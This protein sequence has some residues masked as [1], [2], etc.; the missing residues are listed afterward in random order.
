MKLSGWIFC[1]EKD[2][3]SKWMSKKEMVSSTSDRMQSYWSLSWST[4]REDTSLR[5]LQEEGAKS[6]KA[7]NFC[8]DQNQQ[9]QWN[10]IAMFMWPV[11]LVWENFR[12]INWR[13]LGGWHFCPEPSNVLLSIIYTWVFLPAHTHFSHHINLHN[14]RVMLIIETCVWLT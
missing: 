8:T 3:T 6:L 4:C 12:F 14:R 2:S 5:Q 1:L 7:T 11:N 13:E 10:R 9:Q